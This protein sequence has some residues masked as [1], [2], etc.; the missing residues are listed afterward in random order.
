MELRRVTAHWPHDADKVTFATD[1]MLPY[2]N[3]TKHPP[4]DKP[5]FNQTQHLPVTERVSFTL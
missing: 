4:T 1:G 5:G 3:D 2:A